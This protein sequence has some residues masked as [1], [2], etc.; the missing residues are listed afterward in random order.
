[1]A[2]RLYTD[3]QILPAGVP[4]VPLLVPFMGPIDPP[5]SP[6][7]ARFDRYVE[8]AR[9]LFTMS[10][11]VECDVAVLPFGWENVFA[12]RALEQR[13]QRF[14]DRAQRA[15]KR[16][17]VFCE[18]DSAAPIPLE[19]A[20][21]FRTSLY[22]S[23]RAANEFAMPAWS[24]DLSLLRPTATVP[25]RHDGRPVVGFMGQAKRPSLTFLRN[26]RLELRA[27]VG[28]DCGEPAWAVRDLHAAV[29]AQAIRLLQ[30]SPAIDA[31]ISLRD[32]FAGGSL[33]DDGSFDWEALRRVRRQFV[34]NADSCDYLLCVRGAGNFS[35]R[36]YETMCLG[37]I[38]LFVNTD[39]VLPF[40]DVVDWRSRMVWVE[41]ESLA[42]L[43]DRVV[44]FERKIDD[45]ARAEL[46]AGARSAWE[47]WLSPEGFFAKLV[48]Y[49]P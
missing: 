17:L 41:A 26:V 19:G 11:L 39:C 25:L 5:E 24:G 27:W 14:A 6:E 20:L 31:R 22:D 28:Q 46:Q 48:E 18:S 40:Q 1:M 30:E 42:T 15:G 12:D 32:G 35:Y 23:L 16:L 29:R 10:S 45:E 33:R 21:V 8:V 44:A 36:F 49:F 43:P 37:R 7:H 3:E 2:L 38:P 34:D 4:H 47:Q 9:T 13:A